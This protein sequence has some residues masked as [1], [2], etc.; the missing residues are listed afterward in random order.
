LRSQLRNRFSEPRRL[1]ARL[2]LVVVS[3]S[4][5]VFL[6]GLLLPVLGVLG[7][8]VVGWV[9]FLGVFRLVFVLLGLVFLL[10]GVGGLWVGRCGFARGLVPGGGL[11]S[12]WRG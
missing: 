10:A 2:R 12:G 9:W 3:V 11:C 8:V 1:V 5:G 7:V 4:G 6:R